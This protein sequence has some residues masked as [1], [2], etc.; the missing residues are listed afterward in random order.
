M[1]KAFNLLA[2]R[3]WFQTVLRSVQ[4][5]LYG[6]LMKLRTMGGR[7][8]AEAV[9]P[10]GSRIQFQHVPLKGRDGFLF[11]RDHDA[12]D[13]LT[14]NLVLRQRQIDVWIDAL[15]ARQAWCDDNGATMRFL[16]IPEKHVVYREKI[17]RFL[18]PSPRRPAMQLM[19]AAGPELA[20]KMLYPVEALRSASETK[21]T[22]FKTD[23]HWTPYGAFVAYQALMESFAPERPLEMVSESDLVWKDRPFVGDLGVRFSRERG[24]TM[25]AVESTSP[26]NLVFQNHNFSR[27]AVHVYESERRDLPTCVL[28]RD[29]FSNFLIPYLMKGFSRLVAVSSLS[30]HYDLLEQ[31]KPDVVIF[32]IIERFIATFGMGKTIELPE[33]SL[34]TSF[35]AFS[36]TPLQ[37]LG[38]TP[39]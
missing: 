36:G 38:H 15:K 23:T 7:S 25:S 39:G 4:P 8:E 21:D 24:E 29:S 17:P 32:A 37:A 19:A 33:D 1:D 27:G 2:V 12:L 10:F 11:H 20:A 22:Y 26:Y 14:A 30:C 3:G 13:Q 18:H 5:L 6:S 31:E 9:A 35:E 34:G 16:V 28:F